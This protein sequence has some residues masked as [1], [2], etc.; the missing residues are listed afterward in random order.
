ME[1]VIR[2]NFHVTLYGFGGVVVARDWGKTGFDLMNRMW[3]EVKSRELPNKGINIWV[4]EPGNAMFAG[5]ELIAPPPAD[6]MLERKEISLEK[7]VYFKHIG[8]YDRIKDS[9]LRVSEECKRAGVKTGL[10]YVEVYG[11]WT[12]DASK[13]ETELL[14]AVIE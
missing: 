3:K 12:E 6:S 10:P 1:Y 11:H 9:G 2:Q 4:Y 7:Y 14:W 13:L 5:V 8:S